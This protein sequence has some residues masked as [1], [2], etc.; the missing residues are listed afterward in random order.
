MIGSSK[1]RFADYFVDQGWGFVG[2][3]GSLMAALFD[4]TE[5]SRENKRC[6]GKG[7]KPAAMQYKTKMEFSLEIVA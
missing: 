1:A 6:A 2:Q 5:E 4:T 7:Q 3:K